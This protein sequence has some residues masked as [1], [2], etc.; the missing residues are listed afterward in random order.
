MKKGGSTDPQDIAKNM[1]SDMGIG[2]NGVGTMPMNNPMAMMNQQGFGGF[3]NFMNPMMMANMNNNQGNLGN[4]QQ[5]QQ[6]SSNPVQGNPQVNQPNLQT[7]FQ[8]SFW[9]RTYSTQLKQL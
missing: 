7:L 3:G 4:S 9:Q 8:N 5:N 2:G 1:A 6:N